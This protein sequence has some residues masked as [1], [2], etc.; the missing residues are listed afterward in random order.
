MSRL[1]TLPWIVAA[2]VCL[3]ALSS[4]HADD[5]DLS[6]NVDCTATPKLL[7]TLFARYGYAPLKTIRRQDKWL[8]IQ[9][10]A[11]VKDVGQTGLYSHVVLA[12]DFSVEASYSWASVPV[13]TEGYGMSCGIAIDTHGPAG[14]VSLTRNYSRQK[15]GSGY[16]VTRGV[17]VD[18]EMKYE[19]T[20]HPSKAKSGRLILRR[21]KE[22]IVCLAA[23]GKSEPQELCRVPFTKGTVHQVRVYADPGGS[24]TALD[25]WLGNLRIQADEIT[26]GFPKLE[27]RS[28]WGW[29]VAVLVLLVLTAGTVLIVRQRQS[30]GK[31]AAKEPGRKG[32]KVKG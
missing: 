2:L 3:C 16:A 20:I 31:R 7:D 4:A 5:P 10:P 30:S 19:T 23:D 32:D 9:L 15:G 28:N 1:P 25:A 24:P 29:W 22:E 26:G 12:G 8:H 27:R 6:R 14:N 17:P 18:E 13:P 11:G 21:E